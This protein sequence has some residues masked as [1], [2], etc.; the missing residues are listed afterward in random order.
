MYCYLLGDGFVVPIVS[1]VFV[2][3]GLDITTGSVDC[4]GVKILVRFDDGDGVVVI[5]GFQGSE[6]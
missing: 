6:L 3:A 4:T 1:K 5:E 2:D